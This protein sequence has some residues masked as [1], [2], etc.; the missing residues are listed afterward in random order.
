M[1]YDLEAR[2]FHD[3]IR[4]LLFKAMGVKRR[5]TE[6]HR[7]DN[8]S[9]RR[10][11]REDHPHGCHIHGCIQPLLR[12]KFCEKHTI[13]RRSRKVEVL[14]HYGKNKCLQCCWDG[15][16]V[17]DLDMLSIDHV[18]NDGAEDRRKGR[19]GTSLY[20][21]LLSH[22]YPEGFQTLCFNHQM[23]KEITRKREESV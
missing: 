8:L 11:W 3:K 22:D 19:V 21:Y 23:K 5:N 10:K 4:L 18:N 14:T 13:M 9:Y 16:T 15:C 2:S 20:N 6:Q 12:G 1:K 7:A 17:I